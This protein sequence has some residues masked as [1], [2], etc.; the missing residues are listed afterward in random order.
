MITPRAIAEAL[1]AREGTGS[2]W[3]LEIE[4]AQ[5]GYARVA[6]TVRDDMTNGHGMIHGGMTFALADTAFAYACNSRNKATV[7]QGASI[8]FLASAKCGE[9]LV[10]EAREL[11][12]AGRTGAYAVTVKTTD[13]R[14]IAQFQGQS[15][16]IGGEVIAG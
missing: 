10:A 16:E 12:H 13:G 7:S 6:M 4:D 9:R 3:G 2:Q 14:T 1:L 11:A 8:I 5:E 15:R